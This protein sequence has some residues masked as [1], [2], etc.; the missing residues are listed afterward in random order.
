[1]VY[2]HAIS[3]IVPARAVPLA[4]E[5]RQTVNKWIFRYEKGADGPQKS[6]GL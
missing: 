6:F 2:K 5:T 4:G 3:T 1:M